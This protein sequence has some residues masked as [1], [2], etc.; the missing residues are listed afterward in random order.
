MLADFFETIKTG[1]L[2]FTIGDAID[3]LLIAIIIYSLLKVTSG[4]RASQVLKGLGAFILLAWLCDLLGLSAISWLLGSF[5]NAGI[6][7]V[8]IIFQPELRRALE[9][10]GRGKFFD[11]NFNLNNQEPGGFE[12]KE[13]E[14]AI[15]SMSKSKTGALMVFENKTGLKDVIESGKVLNAQVSTEL[16]ENI[17]FPNS[18]LH[19][20][21]MI[22]EG[23]TIVAAGCFL[24]L[25]DN[26]DL[27]S[28]LG[29]R[30]RAALGISEVSDAKVIIVSEETGV[31]SL[32]SEGTLTRYLDRKALREAL[33]EIYGVRG[34]NSKRIRIINHKS[35]AGG[36][37]S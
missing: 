9:Q 34:Q 24:P 18:P 5:V 25:S 4:T 16:I 36:Q 2:R 10:M 8:V 3:I 23:R 17:F 30:H 32:A 11:I 19:D 35:K 6:L 20:G 26:K 1:V 27:S 29:T 21:A 15:L 33:E 12:I 31:I 7:L 28:E 37:E 14:D 13:L 22:I